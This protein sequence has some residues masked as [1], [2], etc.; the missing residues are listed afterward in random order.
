MEYN[1][2]TVEDEIPYN[3]QDIE[4]V[5]LRKLKVGESFKVRKGPMNNI[6]NSM[7]AQKGNWLTVKSLN[8]ASLSTHHHPLY[9]E[10]R[11]P[12]VYYHVD[13][14]SNSW[15]DYH[16]DIYETNLMILKTDRTKRI[17]LKIK[18][19]LPII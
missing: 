19:S 6:N 2:E 1:Q 5:L 14:G 16:M 15:L 11:I 17:R 18:P 7:D 10:H 3:Q 12:V 9:H 13:D 4:H 8:R